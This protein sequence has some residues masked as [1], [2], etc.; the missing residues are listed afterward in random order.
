MR[1][2]ANNWLWTELCQALAYT[3]AYALSHLLDPSIFHFF[4]GQ[5]KAD[6]NAALHIYLVY[7]VSAN[8]PKLIILDDGAGYY[9]EDLETLSEF[10]GQQARGWKQWIRAFLW[11]ANSIKVYTKRTEAN[12]THLLSFECTNETGL[13]VQKLVAYAGDEFVQRTKLQ[14][15]SLLQL[16]CRT[17]WTQAEFINAVHTLNRIYHK[18]VNAG[19]LL[20]HAAY[21]EQGVFYDCFNATNPVPIASYKEAK[22]LAPLERP[23]FFGDGLTHQKTPIQ[24]V[25]TLGDKK[26]DIRGYGAILAAPAQKEAGIFC[27]VTNKLFR[28]ATVNSAFKPVEIFG[29][30]QALANGALYA[31]LEFRG[32]QTTLTGDD[33][34]LTEPERKELIAALTAAF[35]SCT[36]LGPTNKLTAQ[37]NTVY[38]YTRERDYGDTIISKDEA[39]APAKQVTADVLSAM[40]LTKSIIDVDV[41]TVKKN[42]HDI[43][44]YS[45]KDE[46]GKDYVVQLVRASAKE[47][48]GSWF[49]KKYAP[50]GSIVVYY[51][52]EHPFLKVFSSNKKTQSAFYEFVIYYVLAEE[53]AVSE[54]ASVEE[55]KL[56]INAYLRRE[57]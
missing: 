17:V 29:G 19:R 30:P 45:I 42:R 11:L 10:N 3:P 34:A 26:I 31:E 53:R 48:G 2:Q 40:R 41:K 37:I 6:K 33:F 4:S 9:K 54:G 22:A 57:R 56:L 20:I 27:Y 55:L 21:R 25:V 28:G 18:Y 51:N 13:S 24:T 43:D 14:H 1:D 35:G 50:D 39:V 15:G 46:Y 7:D 47:A 32:I 12:H 49:K 5:Q 44:V 36:D 16:N 23:L 38:R 8:T 52:T